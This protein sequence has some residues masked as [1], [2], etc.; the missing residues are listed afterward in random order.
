MGNQSKS[1]MSLGVITF[2]LILIGSFGSYYVG[3]VLFG[4][5][6]LLTLTL[7]IIN[8]KESPKWLSIINLFL[9]LT[10]I[11]IIIYLTLGN[12]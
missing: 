3:W 8:I 4:W 2:I 9:S 6:S 11:F 5:I 10:F 12:L 7:S 1:K